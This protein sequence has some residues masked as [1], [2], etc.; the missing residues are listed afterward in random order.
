MQQ[1]SLAAPLIE[2]IT[3]ALPAA[4]FLPPTSAKSGSGVCEAVEQIARY[5]RRAPRM[6]AANNLIFLLDFLAPRQPSILSRLPSDLK[7]L[8]RRPSLRRVLCE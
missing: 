1:S 7:L 5:V 3:A 8:V 4:I 2:T 6:C